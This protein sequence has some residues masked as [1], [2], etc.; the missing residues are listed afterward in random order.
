MSSSNMPSSWSDPRYV[1]TVVGVLAT[2]V[3]VFYAALTQSG[4]VVEE[5]VF[6]LLSVTLPATIAYEVARRW[7]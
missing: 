6:V 3:L 1:S 2:G 5:V 7:S 4:L